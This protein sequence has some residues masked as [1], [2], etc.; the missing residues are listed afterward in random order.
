ML[1]EFYQ[2]HLE[3]QLKKADY[4]VLVILINLLQS[5]KQVN[6]EKLATALPLPILFESRRRKLQRFLM[7]PQLTVERIWLPLIS[8]WLKSRKNREKRFI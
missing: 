1:P 4:L 7:L 2:K 3:T 8:Q 6:L 5:I